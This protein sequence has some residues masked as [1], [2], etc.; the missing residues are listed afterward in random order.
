M[1][2]GLRGRG[3]AQPDARRANVKRPAARAIAFGSQAVVWRWLAAACIILIRRELCITRCGCGLVDSYRNRF[4]R[5]LRRSSRLRSWI[6]RRFA[7]TTMRSRFRT[8]RRSSG[9]CRRSS[10]SRRV[11]RVTRFRRHSGGCC[12]AC[13]TGFR[14]PGCRSVCPMI[15]RWCHYET[16]AQGHGF[17]GWVMARWGCLRV[18]DVGLALRGVDSVAKRPDP[19]QFVVIR[20]HLPRVYPSPTGWARPSRRRNTAPLRMSGAMAARP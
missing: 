17:R 7:R 1:A 11:V 10:T 16:S 13:G 3:S 2:A 4:G 15:D 5:S 6:V 20:A 12:S 18:H 8:G 14:R 19:A 9:F